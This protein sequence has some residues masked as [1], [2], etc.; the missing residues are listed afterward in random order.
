MGGL[1]LMDKLWLSAHATLVSLS[2]LCDLSTDCWTPQGPILPPVN[3]DKNYLRSAPHSLVSEDKT[4]ASPSE[5]NLYGYL[6]QTSPSRA[7]G[8]LGECPRPAE[9]R[10][11][12][13]TPLALAR[14]L[15]GV[16]NTAG[17]LPNTSRAFVTGKHSNLVETQTA[18]SGLR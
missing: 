7:T 14:S 5:C 4:H 15:R 18:S 8:F 1:R 3:Q 10:E 13:E 12:A 17:H 16:L 9:G 6:T 2:F 11:E